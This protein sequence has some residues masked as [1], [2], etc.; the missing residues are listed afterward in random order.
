MTVYVLSSCTVDDVE[1]YTLDA[2]E[3]LGIYSTRQKAEAALDE[4]A[5]SY[6]YG[7]KPYDYY[8]DEMEIQ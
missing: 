7:R 2:G 5:K 1:G 3:V 6:N 8:I 4:A